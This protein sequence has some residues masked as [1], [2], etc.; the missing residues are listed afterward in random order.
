MG[1]WVIFRICY[2]GEAEWLADRLASAGIIYVV[3][4]FEGFPPRVLVRPAQLADAQAA[5][6]A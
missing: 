4:R 5:A 1:D 3:N 6:A 2:G